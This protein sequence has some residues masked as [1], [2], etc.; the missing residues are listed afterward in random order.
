MPTIDN[1]LMDGFGEAE[2]SENFNRVLS[3]VDTQTARVGVIDAEQ[4]IGTPVNAVA[5]KVTLT[6]ATLPTENDTM[7]IG[8]KVYTFKATAAADGDIAIG[9]DVAATRLNVVAAINGTGDGQVCAA[10]PD[11]SCAA[12]SSADAVVTAKVKGVAGSAITVAETFTAVGNIFSGAALAG[13]VDGTPGLA[14]AILTDG[15]KIYV[16]TA[17]NTISGANWKSATLA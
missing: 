10:H 9:A 12:F 2:I 17:T 15:S 11:V 1:R 4:G 14:G 3:I 13:G 7:T 16:C 5:A 8:T 6:L